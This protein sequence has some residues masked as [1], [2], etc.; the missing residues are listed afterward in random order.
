MCVVGNRKSWQF[1]EI[2]DFVVK[3]VTVFVLKW[4]KRKSA[5]RIAG[6]GD[7]VGLHISVAGSFSSWQN[8]AVIQ[9]LFQ[10]EI[11]ILGRRTWLQI[12]DMSMEEDQSKDRERDGLK[13]SRKDWAG[14]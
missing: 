1:W 14:G 11:T 10:E 12:E 7:V 5:Q 6:I 8:R 13:I 9:Q 2:G 4:R 3:Y